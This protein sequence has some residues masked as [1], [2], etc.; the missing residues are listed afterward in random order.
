MTIIE[1]KMIKNAE[2]QKEPFL[3]VSYD[4]PSEN[5][6]GLKEPEKLELRTKRL[7]ISNE[8]YLKGTQ[9][10][11]SVYIVSTDR[12][13]HML[14][15]INNRYEGTKFEKL[16]NVRVIGAVFKE[17][18]ISVLKETID[19]NLNDLWE[20]VELIEG[21][22]NDF[23]MKKEASKSDTVDYEKEGKEK[24]KLKQQ[25]YAQNR[26]FTSIDG[27]ILD[28]GKIGYMKADDY[29]E[30]L[31]KLVIKRSSVLRRVNNLGYVW[32]YYDSK[33]NY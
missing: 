28:L 20:R 29:K 6:E 27:K 2:G 18:V 17:T 16:V 1:E 26:N 24:N 32:G 14:E 13:R 23:N 31:R 21:K 10:Q 19:N 30:K 15:F 8:F 12:V 22:V 4:V 33:G 9:V 5:Q 7:L 25:L 11:K 3:V